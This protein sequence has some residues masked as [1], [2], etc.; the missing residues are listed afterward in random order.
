M[1][2]QNYLKE[3][4]TVNK[5]TN[6]LFILFTVLL[7]LV[8]LI[9]VSAVTV[10]ADNGILGMYLLDPLGGNPLAPSIADLDRDDGFNITGSSVRVVPEKLAAGYFVTGWSILNYPAVDGGAQITASATGA[11]GVA[12]ADVIGTVGVASI[13]ATI[14]DGSVTEDISIDKK[15][16]QIYQTYISPPQNV[17]VI[18]NE[19]T[20]TWW[21]TA[22]VTD[23]VTGLFTDKDGNPELTDPLTDPPG[24]VGLQGVILHWYLVNGNLVSSIP[25]TPGFFHTADN[26]GVNDIISNLPRATFTQ[27]KNGDMPDYTS[28]TTFT[29]ASGENTIEVGASGE[30]PVFVVVVPEYPNTSNVLVTPEV[31]Q[32]NFWTAEMEKVPQ[33]R[34]AGEKIVL[35]KFFGTG[36]YPVEAENAG[37]GAGDGQIIEVPWV[38]TPSALAWRTRAP[39]H[40]KALVI[41]SLRPLRPLRRMAMP[42]Q[43]TI[44]SLQSGA[45]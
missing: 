13:I 9:P 6:K 43:S 30:E 41:Q 38:G 12:Y 33:V 10:S 27:I 21:A 37:V 16:A 28:I 45:K 19:S 8:M 24:Q 40:W 44:Y 42:G 35:E 36:T 17:A 34:W 26:K 31:T 25:L 2:Y 3:A 1:I 20:K 39:V 18:W 5:K 22:N 4:L 7:T 11:G 14:S 15:W 32:V 23:R 29:G